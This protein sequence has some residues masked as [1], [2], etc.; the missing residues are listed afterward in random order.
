METQ[1]PQP[2]NIQTHK[3]LQSISLIAASVLFLL[4]V[5]GGLYSGVQLGKS[6]ATYESASA[7]YDALNYFHQDQGS[8]PSAE[9][10]Y[11]QQILV[12]YKYLNQFPKPEDASG[13]CSAYQDFIYT[14]P[15]S[16]DFQLQFCLT[17]PVGGYNAGVNVINGESK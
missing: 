9:Q 3:R 14:R 13:T 12:S 4:C 7:I 17:Q 6:K 5:F 10:F 8:Y 1:T 11:N 16:S 15:S 2:E